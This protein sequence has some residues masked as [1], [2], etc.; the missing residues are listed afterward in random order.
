MDVQQ[1]IC[2][3]ILSQTAGKLGES[4]DVDYDLIE[5][6][7]MDSLFMMGVITHLE[8]RYQMQFGLHDIVPRNFRTIRTLSDFVARALADNRVAI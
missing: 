3:Y 6:G 2:H 5:S 7:I 4:V 1:D 8:Q